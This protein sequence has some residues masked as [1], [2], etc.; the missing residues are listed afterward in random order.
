[1][2]MTALAR[3]AETS[4]AQSEELSRERD[5]RRRAEEDAQLKQQLLAQSVD[6]KIR[7]GRDLHDGIIQSLYAVG[8]T[9][10]TVRALVK[11]NPAEADQR[12]ERCRENL[13]GIIREVRTYITGL[14]PDTVRRATFTQALDTL[15]RELASDCD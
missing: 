3:L 2:E 14:T 10:E 4:V 8:L 15:F 1:T 6:E 11:N 9:L 12:L 13:N 7:L 5:V